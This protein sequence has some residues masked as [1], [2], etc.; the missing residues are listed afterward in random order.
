MNDTN[1]NKT[2][3]SKQNKN[4]F[5]QNFINKKNL[6]KHLVMALG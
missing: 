5:F 4:T 3:S 1:F 2:H 6:K